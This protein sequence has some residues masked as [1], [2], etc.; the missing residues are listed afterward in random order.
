MSASRTGI[1]VYAVVPAASTV[2]EPTGVAGAPVDTIPVGD[3]SLVTSEV[4]LDDLAALN[5]PATDPM[6]LGKLAER[7]DAVV[8][9]ALDTSGSVLPFRLGTVLT[10]R[11][12]AT[13]FV[14][15]QAT[16]LR[17]TLTHLLKCREWGVKVR[18][19]GSPEPASE[20]SGDREQGVD[21]P[22]G[23]K[24]GTAYLARRRQ[25][26][27]T[28]ERRQQHRSEV[29]DDVHR[30]LLDVAVESVAGAGRESGVLSDEVYLVRTADEDRFLDTADELAERLEAEGLTLRVT[31]PWPPYSFARPRERPDA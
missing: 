21:S 4:N 11:D 22:T 2:N 18:D 1:Y 13:Q 31:G 28:A 15:T 16:E 25:Q 30:V 19:R 27:A 5:D 23:D 6:S 7:H 17:Q 29:V 3:L 24:P 20:G 26:F 8:R 9:A 10:D 12:A 14:T